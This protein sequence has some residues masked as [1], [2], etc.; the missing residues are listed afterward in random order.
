M[1]A[2]QAVVS[3]F[4]RPRGIL[5]HI[6]GWV[7]ANRG[8]N[9]L[10]NR[11]TVDLLDPK[12]GETV[13]EAGCGPGVALQLCLSRESVRA[14]GVDHSAV[15]IAQAH[16]RNRKA[17]QAGRLKLFEGTIDALP[18]GWGPFDKLF[19][20]N[21]VQFVEQA[22]FIA[23]ARQVLKPG[24]MFAATYQPRHA[25]ATRADAISMAVRLSEILKAQGFSSVRTEELEL[26]PVPAVCVLAV[27]G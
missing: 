18:D 10:R 4:V 19:S 26:K 5:G 16:K 23:R 11:W 12:G 6:A 1:S 9:V 8:S 17:I 2:R 3:Q 7:L 14:I 24:G 27:R 13:L 22:S 20:I 15:M 25:K 21:V